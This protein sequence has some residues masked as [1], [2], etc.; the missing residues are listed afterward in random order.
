MFYSSVHKS[1]LPH[2]PIS[3]LEL[4]CTRLPLGLFIHLIYAMVDLEWSSMHLWFVVDLILNIPPHS[5]PHVQWECSEIIYTS[6]YHQLKLRS[7]FLT[8][9]LPVLLLLLMPPSPA[10]A[11]APVVVVAA[12]APATS[13]AAV[14]CCPTHGF[15]SCCFCFRRNCGRPV[16]R[17]LLLH[18]APPWRPVE[19]M[20]VNS[21]LL[22]HV[23]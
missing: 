19:L 6:F 9:V 22:L 15:C 3:R 5:M 11:A 12:A 17:C 4:S 1:F 21:R 8:S 10:A 20:T 7:H 14:L 23:G 13:A 18:C 16:N 2:N